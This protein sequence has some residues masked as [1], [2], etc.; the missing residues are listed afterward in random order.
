MSKYTKFDDFLE[1]VVNEAEK[2]NTSPQFTRTTGLLKNGWLSF[3]TETMTG[4]SSRRDDMLERAKQLGVRYREKF[5]THKGE[6]RYI[7][8]LQENFVN[9]LLNQSY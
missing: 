7:D 9:E 5:E 6:E 2:K 8:E 3:L 4:A 1:E